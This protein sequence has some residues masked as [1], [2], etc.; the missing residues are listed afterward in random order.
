VRKRKLLRGKWKTRGDKSVETRIG[1]GRDKKENLVE[2]LN[3]WN[4]EI[5]M[6]NKPM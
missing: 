4:V 3:Q 1:M 2:S 5:V 6:F